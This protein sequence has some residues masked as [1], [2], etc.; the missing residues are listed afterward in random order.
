MKT[1]FQFILFMAIAFMVIVIAILLGNLGAWYFAWLVGTAMIVLVA[2]AGGALLD[3]QEEVAN[4]KAEAE[5]ANRQ[6]H[7][8]A[9]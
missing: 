2:A 7:R 6:Q 4:R 3:T 1:T 8:P 5:A 9:R